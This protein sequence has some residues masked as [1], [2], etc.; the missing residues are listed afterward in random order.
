MNSFGRFFAAAVLFLLLSGAA[1]DQAG[2][3]ERLYKI[4][5]GG[6]DVIEEWIVD[7]N[8]NEVS[9]DYVETDLVDLATGEIRY[10]VRTRSEIGLDEDGDMAILNFSSLLDLAGNTLIDWEIGVYFSAFGEC[11][12]RG[13][14]NYHG[15]LYHLPTG[16]ESHEG[17]RHADKLGD[18]KFLLTGWEQLPLGIVNG[19]GEALS[20]FQIPER[21]D[22]AVYVWNEYIIARSYERSA[23]YL[24]DGSL[25]ELFVADLISQSTGMT[26]DYLSYERGDERGVFRPEEGIVFSV[27]DAYIE[28]YDG[29]LAIIREG[30]GD[31][32][33][34]ALVTREHGEIAG[35]FSWLINDG[36]GYSSAPADRFIGI[37]DERAVFIDREGNVLASSD[38]IP[39]AYRLDRLYEG[40]Y[41]YSGGD[42]PRQSGLLGPNL[43]L[44]T[45]AGRY[46]Y[47]D[48]AYGWGEGE[49]K[50]AEDIFIRAWKG[51]GPLD[52]Y[53]MHA[54]NLFDILDH[55]G[56][57]V[58]D[59][60]AYVGDAGSDRIVIQRGFNIGLMDRDGNWVV[61]RR[62]FSNMI[63]D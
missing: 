60:A 54:L 19:S 10:K 37:L 26:G 39:N 56:R 50:S 62:I 20:D 6:W 12:I 48:V 42:F 9:R 33:K 30:Y 52:E 35:G 38:K 36:D 1:S 34:A 7:R 24:L 45:P 4:P 21:Y 23:M 14:N 49:I 18:G 32:T 25:N 28:Y 55:T 46:T 15:V 41:A 61:K 17:V 13:Y 2:A 29:E 43:E 59:N 53:G 47:L 3:G 40:I 22:D 51:I 31:D 58:T 5:F 44:L 27:N 8:G 16:K 63:E 57:V 11:I